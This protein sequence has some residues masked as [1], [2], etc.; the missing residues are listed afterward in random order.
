MQGGVPQGA[1]MP[2][3][4]D[5]AALE[6]AAGILFQLSADAYGAL[7]YTWMSRLPLEAAA[8]RYA[9]RVL[10]AARR[11]APGA[12]GPGCAVEPEGPGCAADSGPPVPS[13]PADADAA[14]WYTC[15]EARKGA[16][17]AAQNRGDEDCGAVLA[18][19][20]K[21]AHEIDRLMG[22]LRFKPDA[23]GRYVAR[24]APDY[25]V[26]PALAPHFTRRFGNTP[27]AVI[28]ERRGLALI[29]EGG[30]PRL[31]AAGEGRLWRGEAPGPAGGPDSR[32]FEPRA[33]DAA[34]AFDP[35]EEIWRSYHRVISIESR[36]NLRLQGQFIPL[37]YREYLSEFGS[38]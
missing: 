35:W 3:L 1:G 29:R 27:W 37:R 26:L 19:A 7:V 4:P 32:A 22:F 13:G 12:E 14:A 10:G 30:P 31:A 33:F 34:R 38:G 28:D 5:P 21:V 23:R 6:G 15:E 24:C 9:L 20:Y 11:A 25:L 8:L 2:L 16:E 36:K 18:A 17:G